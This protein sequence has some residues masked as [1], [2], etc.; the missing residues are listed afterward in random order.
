MPFAV[1]GLE[2]T[3]EFDVPHLVNNNLSEEE[4]SM[5]NNERAARADIKPVELRIDIDELTERIHFDEDRPDP[6]E[7][8]TD[9]SIIRELLGLED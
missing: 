6:A 1:V 7:S 4:N 5:C 8:V 9:P 2:F 3:Q